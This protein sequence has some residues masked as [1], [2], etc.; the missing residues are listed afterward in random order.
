MILSTQRPEPSSLKQTFL[1]TSIVYVEWVEY[2]LYLY[3]GTV[4][5][6]YFFPQALGD[7]ALLFTYGIFAISYIGRPLGGLL[8]GYYADKRGRRPPLIIS[9]F[10]IAFATTSIGLIPSYEHIGIIAPILLLICRFIQSIA[11]AGEFNNA[12][13][14]LIEHARTKKILAGSWVGCAAS[15]GMFTGGLI[16]YILSQIEYQNAWRFAFVI[17]GIFSLLIMYFRSALSES[18]LFTLARSQKNSP[19][20]YQQLTKHKLGLL[21][22]AVI[23]AF[24][25]LYI[26]T[27]NVYFM[28][29]MVTRLG[30]TMSEA[31]LYMMLTQAGVTLFIPIMAM[32]A[33]RIGLEIMMKTMIPSICIMALILFWGASVGSDAIIIIGLSLYVIANSGISASIFKYMF[34]ILPLHIR[35]TGTSFIYS[36][37]VAIVGGSAPILAAFLINQDYLM[38]PAYYICSIGL[39]SFILINLKTTWHAER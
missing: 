18:P 30:Y 33:E 35:C 13:I 39:I 8:F 5:S 12:S 21:K 16:A 7:N 28:S 31:S 15:A 37:S 10:L 25:C 1:T 2:A 11:V 20:L 27:C 4:I 22:I 38:A 6:H 29:Y 9:A 36:L 19:S 3:L 26:Y 24:M 32:I 17:A 14:Y 34:D 23:A